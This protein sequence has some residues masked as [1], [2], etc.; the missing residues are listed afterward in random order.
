MEV[1]FIALWERDTMKRDPGVTSL[2][3]QAVFEMPR[4][5]GLGNSN[6]RWGGGGNGTVSFGKVTGVTVQIRKQV[7]AVDTA[8]PFLRTQEER[9]S[10][11]VGI[12]E[13][14]YRP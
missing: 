13:R 11:K 7:H 1:R 3:G 10:T 6:C 12:S 9:L 2:R 5:D 14:R 8:A 4:I